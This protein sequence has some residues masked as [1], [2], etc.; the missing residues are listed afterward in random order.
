MHSIYNKQL[1]EHFP[2][3]FENGHT[4]ETLAFWCVKCG[5]TAQDTEVTGQVSRIIPDA[6]DI[7]ATYQCN[8]GYTNTYR[9]RL[10]DD[11]SFTWLTDEVWYERQP[12]KL[13]AKNHLRL[14]GSQ[15]AYLIRLKWDCFWLHR[16]LKKIR[17]LIQISK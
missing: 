2:L 10:K 11:K 14:W 16:R 5:K 17:N 8:C 13:S 12:K 4:I 6:A 3:H 1:A 15:T 7:R 9:I